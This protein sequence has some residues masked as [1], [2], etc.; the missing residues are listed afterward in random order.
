MKIKAIYNV[1]G[2]K[3]K[4]T[5]PTVYIIAVDCDMQAA[6][7]VEPIADDEAKLSVVPMKYLQIIDNEYNTYLSPVPMLKSNYVKPTVFDGS[8]WQANSATYGKLGIKD[9]D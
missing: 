4:D 2:I 7:I 3:T 9:V 8:K 1:N 5:S 6:T